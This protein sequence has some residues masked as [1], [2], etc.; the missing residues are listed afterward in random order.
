MKVS[1]KATDEP[2]K[3][4]KKD[5]KSKTAKPSP[6]EEPVEEKKQAEEDEELELE[7]EE[8]NEIVEYKGK[9]YGKDTDG[10]IICLKRF[11]DVGKWD[12]QNKKIVFN[13]DYEEE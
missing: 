7:A 12:E 2:K 11:E 5:K 10:S 6:L 13:D 9:K 1:K 3:A 4:V 8:D